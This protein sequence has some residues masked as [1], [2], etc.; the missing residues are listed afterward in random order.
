MVLITPSFVVVFN[1][2]EPVDIV[3]FEFHSLIY[4][5]NCK[6]YSCF[7]SGLFSSNS[8]SALVLVDFPLLSYI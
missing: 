5:F 1:V 3:F 8:R 6:I 2:V 4:E 7:S